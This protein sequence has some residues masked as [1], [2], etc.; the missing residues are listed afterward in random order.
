MAL[1]VAQSEGEEIAADHRVRG[2]A[3]FKRREY[4]SAVEAYTAALEALGCSVATNTF[5]SNASAADAPAAGGATGSPNISLR[6]P[7][8]T[9]RAL[10]R[11]R[12]GE[13]AAAAEDAEAA[14]RLQPGNVKAAFRAAAARLAL[15]D[16]IAAEQHAALLCAD[17]SSRGKEAGAAPAGWAAVAQRAAAMAAHQRRVEAVQR[18]LAASQA[19]GSVPQ[20]VAALLGALA[21]EAEGEDVELAG[22]PVA[23]LHQL[24][25]LL[26]A[27]GSHARRTSDRGCGRE[28]AAGAEAAAVLCAA[29]GQRGWRLLLFFL[30][31]PDPTCQAAAAAALRA[32][33]QAAAAGSRAVQWP[34]EVWRRLL[35]AAATPGRDDSSRA[36][37]AAAMQLLGWAA[38][39]D[40][41]VRQQLLTHPLPAEVSPACQQAGSE[42]S[43]LV[44]LTAMLEDTSRLHRMAPAAVVAA[45]QLLRLYASDSVAAEV[46]GNL[47]C[48][49]LL[50]LLRAADSADGMA[51]FAQPSDNA[52]GDSAAAP[53]PAAAGPAGEAADTAI[54][55]DSG[56][57]G[58]G[59]Q[60]EDPEVVALQALRKKR[61]AIYDKELVAVRRALL[62]A[63]AELADGCR[64]LLLAEC[65]SQQ[66]PASAGGGKRRAAAGAF[67]TELL[68]LVRQ[69]HGQQPR[70][71][72]PV[73]GPDGMPR[74]YAKRRFAADYRDN[75]A[76]DFLL[77]LDLQDGDGSPNA[78]STA[79]GSDGRASNT[80]HAAQ[81]QRTLLELA[82][83]TL[84]LAACASPSVAALLHRRDLFALCDE[85]AGYCT[86]AVVSAAQRLYA[87][88][89]DALPTAADELLQSG[90]GSGGL[91]G[92]DGSGS[93]AGSGAVAGLAGLVLYSASPQRQ[94]GALGKLAAV[95]DTCSGDDFALL[96]GLASGAA[97]EQTAVMKAWQLA[98]AAG[99]AASGSAG[100][101]GNKPHAGLQA[102][103][104]RLMLRCAERAQR[105]QGLDAGTPPRGGA[106]NAIGR[107]ALQQLLRS[108]AQKG[109]A[110]QA[111]AAAAAAKKE[112]AGFG[113]SLKRGFFAK[114]DAAASA[115]RRPAPPAQPSA[116]TSRSPEP[117]TNGGSP[118]ASASS[119]SIASTSRYK[120]GAVVIEELEEAEPISAVPEV[121][122]AAAAAAQSESTRAAHT[123]LPGPP[124][125]KQAEQRQ[126]GDTASAAM[127]AAEADAD[128]EEP[129][130]D[131]PDLQ[132]VFDSSAA[133]PAEQRRE[134][135]AWAA[136]PLDKKLKWTQTSSDVSATLAL[137]AGTRAADVAVSVG[138]G[139]LAVSLR[140]YGRV[141]GGQLHRPVKAS[142]THWCLEGGELHLLLA[143]A[144]DAWWRSLL[145]GDEQKSFYEVLQE[146]VHA[147]EPVQPYD[148]LDD[149]AKGLIEAI[150]ERQ[151]YI[152]A[153]LI[154][155]EGFDDFR[156]VLGESG[157]GGSPG[158]HSGRSG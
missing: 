112:E 86:P 44:Q 26:S 65:V 129:E 146:A 115:P 81:E 20:R 91:S 117:H 70:R 90:A 40:S 104:R 69:L 62:A 15:G 93:S 37:S 155:P 12:I 61:R 33:G 5:S 107:Q 66:G 108:E 67:L 14:L 124:Q 17:G 141:L 94:E 120:Q 58:A 133:V 98:T 152:N 11:H 84:L 135:S 75:P 73:L 34:A 144:D 79:P 136:L 157:L 51:A 18:Q 54:D 143:K 101:A 99:P 113:G 30:A 43:P 4:S 21:A 2:N 96:T 78:D 72:T 148:Q 149:S 13:Y 48:R 24:A 106:W 7:L 22:G 74:A 145:E 6:V 19:E 10:A 59:G 123:S 57:S 118:A 45:A 53:G 109:S 95:A 128:E 138:D 111:A 87:A 29:P 119:G 50:A 105:Q 137:P 100:T 9:N 150:Q 158:K 56:S 3:A 131:V 156:V 153:G 83:E 41:W 49:P 80:L 139:Q 126:L 154:D 151:A 23:L 25:A 64:E 55:S 1:A 147:D 71:T 121:P 76:G 8:L 68:A 122:P 27:D 39:R 140:W 32:A 130:E 38:E 31:D 97:A 116:A 46:L 16:G 132:D 77:S 28:E 92:G 88:L 134:R 127:E 85:L 142:E 52:N 36:G 47:G 63:L 125:P 42:D 110:S 35:A 102:A 60:P 89:A 114:P 103:A 82:L